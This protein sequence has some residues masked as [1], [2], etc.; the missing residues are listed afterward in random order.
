MPY[1]R[2]EIDDAINRCYEKYGDV[3]EKRFYN[4]EELLSIGPVKRVYGSLKN[5]LDKNDIPENGPGYEYSEEEIREELIACYEEYGK[6]TQKI[7]DNSDN[8]YP[9]MKTLR[10]RFGSLNKILKSFDIPINKKSKYTKDEIDEHLRACYEKYG[11]VSVAI[12]NN[13]D[14][15][16][17]RP[18]ISRFYGGLPNAL[19][20]LGIPAHPNYSEEMYS[21]KEIDEA[22][23]ECYNKHGDISSD[24]FN[25]DSEFPSIT[26]VLKIYESWKQAIYKNKIPVNRAGSQSYGYG[27]NWDSKREEVINKDNEECIECGISREEHRNKYKCDLHV[28]HIIPRSH[29]Y[30]QVVD[31]FDYKRANNIDNLRTMCISCHIKSEWRRKN[32]N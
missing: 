7:L 10:N 18:V 31:V 26:P 3:K 28:D 20:S 16:P 11:E 9:T 15:L 27:P 12:L 23:N 2:K 13:D 5:A 29:Y 1:S 19:K 32:D 22:L 14:E 17:A 30:N 6:V 24:I 4:D 8:D 21:K 25:K